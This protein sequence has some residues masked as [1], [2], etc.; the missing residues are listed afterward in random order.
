MNM[1]LQNTKG[2]MPRWMITRLVIFSLILLSVLMVGNVR[3]VECGT[4]PTDGC[5]VS[6][7]TTLNTFTSLEVEPGSKS[8]LITYEKEECVV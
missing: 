5:T 1:K 4:T 7:D 6:A 8:I 3:A 2:I